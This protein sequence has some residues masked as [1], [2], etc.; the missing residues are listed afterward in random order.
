M[1]AG[2]VKDL[3]ATVRALATGAPKVSG[4]IYATIRLELDGDTDDGK[5]W[6]DTHGAWEASPHAFPA[7]AY[8]AASDWLYQLPAAATTSKVSATK[9]ARIRWRLTDNASTPASETAS[10]AEFEEM[11]YSSGAAEAATGAAASVTAGV[12][13]AADQAVNVTKWSGTAVPTPDTAGYPKVTLKSGTGT[14]EVN[15]SSGAV[16]VTGD[17]TATMK[18][19]VT[20][21]ATAATPTVVAGTVSDKTGYSL[22]TAPLDAAGTRTALGLGSANLDTQLGTIASSASSAASS[23]SSAA[24]SAST[25][26][27]QAT[28]AASDALLARK[29]LEADL[30]LDK[31]T[32]PA[33]WRVHFYE[34]GTTSDLIPAKLLKS[35]TGAAVVAATTP[36]G[37]QVQP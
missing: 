31:T 27:T 17:L 36:V 15:I 14:G 13:L 22:A 18:T 1:I 32:D 29:L 8:D 34:R 10:S 21:A 11:V 7:A 3:V 23:S 16:P 30:V 19:S 9:P 26:A 6:C 33:A 5:R 12:T 2:I 25:A 4:T 35:H 24:S 28:N 20:T 37:S